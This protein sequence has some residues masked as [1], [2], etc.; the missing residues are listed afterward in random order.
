[1]KGQ[2][3]EGNNKIK[4]LSI[5]RVYAERI[6]DGTKKIELRK[7]SIG[8]NI[9]DLILLYETTPNSV[10]KGGFIAD[11]TISL[12]V[13]EMW[14]KYSNLLGVEKSFY[15]KYFQNSAFAY[16]TFVHQSFSFPPIS[17]KKL[18]QLCPD[19]SPPQATINWRSNWYILPEWLDALN[20]GKNNL[21]LSEQLS[22]PIS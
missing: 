6:I 3:T 2:Y 4:A 5:K 22:L 20:Q 16:G 1:M 14:G 19:F 15:D 18:R 9:G 17:L 12:P 11:Q 21:K 13:E 10:I 8:M 7:R